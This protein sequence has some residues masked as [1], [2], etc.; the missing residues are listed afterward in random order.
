MAKKV[1]SKREAIKNLRMIE[2][3][4]LSGHKMLRDV[5]KEQYRRPVLSDL[6]IR[7]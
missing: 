5:Y 1:T 4:F 6:W 7:C 2:K 3:S